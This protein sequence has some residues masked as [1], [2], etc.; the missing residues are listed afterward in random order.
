MCGWAGSQVVGV[1]STLQTIST[2][3]ELK[4]VLSYGSPMVL[5]HR[6]EAFYSI[7]DIVDKLLK[8]ETVQEMMKEEDLEMVECI[9]GESEVTTIK[10]HSNPKHDTS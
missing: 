6:V 9:N 7:K 2:Q 4:L 3:L 1:R 8:G 10:S 5:F